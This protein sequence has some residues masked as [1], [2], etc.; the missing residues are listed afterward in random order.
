MSLYDAQRNHYWPIET[1]TSAV[2]IS[3]QARENRT[4]QSR[5]GTTGV[6]MRTRRS[7]YK[8]KTPCAT[9]HYYMDEFCED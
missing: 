5:C 7:N 6:D 1:S 9:R 2:W 4:V 3:A 8:G